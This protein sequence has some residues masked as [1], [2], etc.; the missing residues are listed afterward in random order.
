[1]LEDPPPDAPEAPDAELPPPAAEKPPTVMK[2]LL[3]PELLD[4]IRTELLVLAEPPD[5]AFPPDPPVP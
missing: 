3:A 4:V 5:A 1:M 2:S